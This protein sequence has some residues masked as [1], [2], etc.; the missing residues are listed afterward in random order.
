MVVLAL[1][2]FGLV[3]V[4][5]AVSTVLGARRKAVASGDCDSDSQ[6][7]VVG[8]LNALFTVVLAFYIVFTW[9]NGDDIE[10]ATKKEANALADIHWQVEFAPPASATQIQALT[11]RYAGKSSTTSGRRWITVTGTPKSRV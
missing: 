10:K 2:G 1:L 11:S 4:A 3:A 8:V 6:S 5:V 7:F 9:Q